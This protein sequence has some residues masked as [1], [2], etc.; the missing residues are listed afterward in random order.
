MIS[1]LQEQR[2][3]F[4]G[5]KRPDSSSLSSSTKKKQ[6]FVCLASTDSTKVPNPTNKII[7]EAA[8]LG[9]KKIMRTAQLVNFTM[10]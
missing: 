1:V 3:L 8:G 4:A 2:N 7:L 6:R 9:E 5:S 10:T